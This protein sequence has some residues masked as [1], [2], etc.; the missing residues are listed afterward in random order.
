MNLATALAAAAIRPHHTVKLAP[1]EFCARYARR[2][3]SDVAIG[4][5]PI[6]ERDSMTASAEAHKAAEKSELTGSALAERYNELC[7]CN[8][9]AFALTDPNNAG[10]AYFEGGGEE[11]ARALLPRT[12][13]R[14]LGELEMAIVAS[15]PLRPEATEDDLAAL[16]ERLADAEAIARLPGPK[17]RRVRQ[18]LRFCLDEID[19]GV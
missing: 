3:K 8:A 2:P 7:A 16:R 18:W 1:D 12:I 15:S 17:A 9:L 5:R 11:I 19:G 14:L 4:V 13:D 6:S 10:K